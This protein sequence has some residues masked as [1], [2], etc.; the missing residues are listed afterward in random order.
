MDEA[1]RNALMDELTLTPQTCEDLAK[2]A[3]VDD[4]VMAQT[5]LG[6]LAHRQVVVRTWVGT[7]PLYSLIE[8]SSV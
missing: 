5:I 6:D 8:T 3:E 4:I 1:T 7:T 2:A